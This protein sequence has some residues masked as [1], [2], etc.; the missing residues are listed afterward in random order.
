MVNESTETMV[1]YHSSA[2]LE[3]IHHKWILLE[4]QLLLLD[5]LESHQFAVTF[6]RWIYFEKG[7]I[8][9]DNDNNDDDYIEYVNMNVNAFDQLNI[10]VYSP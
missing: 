7:G 9:L 1:T 2:F 6:F 8:H 3:S 10:Y 4:Y 5:F